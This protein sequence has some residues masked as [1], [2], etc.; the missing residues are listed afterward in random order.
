MDLIDYI[1][2]H[3]GGNQ[4]AFARSQG[5]VRQQVTKW[6]RAGWVVHNGRLYSPMRELKQQPIAGIAC[7][8][9]ESE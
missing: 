1:A 6:L 7:Q 8:G 5:V 3:H 9:K 4:S 2:K